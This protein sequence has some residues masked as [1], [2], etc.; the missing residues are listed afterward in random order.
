SNLYPG[1]LYIVQSID[2]ILIGNNYRKR[3]NYSNSLLG[4]PDFTCSNFLIEGIGSGGGLFSPT[5]AGFC[6]E[7]MYT[8][9]CFKQDGN[10]LYYYQNC[11]IIDTSSVCNFTVS[12]PE[13]ESKKLFTLSPNPTHDF[14]TIKNNQTKELSIKIFSSI[15]EVVQKTT[16]GKD[17]VTTINLSGLAAGIY[18]VTARSDRDFSFRKLVKQ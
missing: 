2:S 9:S 14:I 15:G 11:T 18:M 5:C 6:F 7:Q 1:T 10:I 8:L 12:I 16:L 13:T 3:F 17:A 4:M